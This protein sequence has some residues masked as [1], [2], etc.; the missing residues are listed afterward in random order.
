MYVCIPICVYIYS[1]V[2]IHSFF[3]GYLGCVHALAILN[4]AAVSIECRYFFDIVTSFL[5][6]VSPEVELLNHMLVL[7]LFF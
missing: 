6:A 2:F 3:D 4:N 5:L 1:I 7:F